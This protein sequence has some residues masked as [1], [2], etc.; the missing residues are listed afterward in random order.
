MTY[1][2]PYP[3]SSP[4]ARRLPRRDDLLRK[5]GTAADAAASHVLG[6]VPS[7]SGSPAEAAPPPV[8]D[9]VSLALGSPAEAAVSRV[10]SPAFSVAATF[11]SPAE[12]AVSRD[13][14]P[15][16]SDLV[17]LAH[18]FLFFLA[19]MAIWAVVLLFRKHNTVAFF[20]VPQQVL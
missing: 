12:A 3:G 13:P 17:L 4:R 14:S 11:A 15:A 6:S 7:A 19:E 1:Q 9:S 20:L 8:P 5:V 18:L 2:F 10:P 16:C